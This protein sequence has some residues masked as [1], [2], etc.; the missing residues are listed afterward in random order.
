[1]VD[2][3]QIQHVGHVRARIAVQILHLEVRIRQEATLVVQL[4]QRRIVGNDGHRHLPPHPHPRIDQTLDVPEDHRRDFVLVGE[5]D[6]Q[7]QQ[8]KDKVD[9]FLLPVDDRLEQNP[10]G[11]LIEDV[12]DDI[13]VVEVVPDQV[14]VEFRFVDPAPVGGQLLE[15]IQLFQIFGDDFVFVA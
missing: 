1:M 6:E 13:V 14:V 3:G 7:R 11:V 12:V 2:V 15:L 8:H 5:N 10:A 4:G 9:D